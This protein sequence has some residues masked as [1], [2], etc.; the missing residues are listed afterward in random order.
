MLRTNKKEKIAI[1]LI[2]FFLPSPWAHA[3][4]GLKLQTHGFFTQGYIKSKDNNFFGNSSG[5]GSF[6]FT[7]IGVNA[8]IQPIAQLHTSAQL[9]L[10]QAGKSDKSDLALD[11]AII[12]YRLQSSPFFNSGIRVG[13]IKNPVGFYNE[14]RDVAFTR[15]G[16]ILPQSIYFDRVRDFAL[17]SDG[18]QAY[19]FYSSPIVDVQIQLSAAKPLLSR[20]AEIALFSKDLPGTLNPK[21]SY[22][23]KINLEF[24]QG[25]LNIAYSDIYLNVDYN[26]TASEALNKPNLT[27]NPKVFSARFLTKNF[28]FSA[29]YALRKF[30]FNNMNSYAPLSSLTGESYYFQIVYLLNHDIRLLARYDVTYQNKDDKSGEKFST[31]SQGTRPDFTQFAKDFTI[32]VQWKINHSWLFMLEQHWVQGVAWLPMQDNIDLSQEQPDFGQLK[33]DWWMFNALVSYRF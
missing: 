9:L 16:V 14:T 31:L 19:G 7:E 33:R 22:G 11:F 5:K 18:G 3:D 4:N 21:F 32:G 6:D 17:S 27:F 15:P 1:C 13:R 10:R 30:K 20:D 23:S 29:E 12:D 28:I 25:K 8:S 2:L 26:A 24:F